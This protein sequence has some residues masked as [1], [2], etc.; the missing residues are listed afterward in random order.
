VL[1]A[2]CPGAA[3]DAQGVQQRS[4]VEMEP[5]IV[6]LILAIVA[7]IFGFGGIASAITNIAVILFWVFLG[8][9][10]IGALFRLMSG[11]WWYGHH[12][13]DD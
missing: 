12:Q 8:L 13:N 7:V 6:L 9:F 4:E 10:L 5:V 2:A 3:G 11:H 1:R